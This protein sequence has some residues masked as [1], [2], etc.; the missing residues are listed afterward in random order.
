MVKGVPIR[1]DRPD[2]YLYKIGDEKLAEVLP[3]R[4][5][6][7]DKNWKAASHYWFENPDPRILVRAADLPKTTASSTD[8]VE[9]IEEKIYPARIK[10]KVHAEEAVPVL[11]K[12]SHFPRWN[13]WVEGKAAKIYQVA[14]SLMLVYGK[15]NI[16]LEYKATLVD[17]IGKLLTIF[18][19]IFLFF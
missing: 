14:P 17:Q 2:F 9:L 18:G 11:I 15:G 4:P 16:R 10:L 6:Y 3:Y 19:I 13:A 1:R 12:T 8:T 5:H 7:T